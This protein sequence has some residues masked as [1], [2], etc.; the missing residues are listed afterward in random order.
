LRK[1]GISAAGTVNK[2]L[3]NFN[4]YFK[5]DRGKKPRVLPWGSLNRVIMRPLIEVNTPPKEPLKDLVILFCWRD[6]V[7]VFFM[8]IIYTRKG[9][10]LCLRRRIRDLVTPLKGVRRLFDF[11]RDSDLMD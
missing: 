2:S 3:Y 5:E 7:I 10:I 1:L 11:S 4:G 6:S 8:S 9:F